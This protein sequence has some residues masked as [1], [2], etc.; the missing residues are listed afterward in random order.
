MARF[1]SLRNLFTWIPQELLRRFVP[2]PGRRYSMQDTRRERIDLLLVQKGLVGSREKAKRLIMA[3][4]VFVDQ[5]RVDKPGTM[6]Q[7]GCSIQIKGDDNPFVSRGG[8]K[9]EKA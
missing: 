1:W 8:L 5:Q 7:S 4:L 2:F 9:L 6:I 3:G